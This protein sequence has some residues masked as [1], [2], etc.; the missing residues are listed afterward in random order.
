MPLV[1]PLSASSIVVT[2]ASSGIG[3]ATALLLAREGADLVL[4][5]RGEPGLDR[6]TAACVRLGSRAVAA[7]ADVADPEQVEDVYRTA[8]AVHGAVDAWA[9]VAGVAYYGRL[10]DAPPAAVL[11]VLD[12]NLMAHLYAV[13]SAAGHMLARG[14]GV[15]VLVG[16]ALSEL[17]MPYL[18]AYSLSKHALAALAATLRQELDPSVSV[19]TVMPSAVA[20][21]LF[22][23]AGNDTGR[24]PRPPGPPIPAWRAARRIV[25]LIAAPRRRSYTGWTGAVSALASRLAPGTAERFLARYGE[26][27]VL[28][29]DV[30]APPTDGN[31]YAAMGSAPCRTSNG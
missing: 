3:A 21:P 30:A 1:S 5:A 29:P 23:H 12:V 22:S 24:R 20:T 27:A 13:R 6:I 19:C 9:G 11:R 17:T 14:G 7:P 2:G 28:D 25:R 4:T 16:S 26:R 18:G 31:L 8:L 10:A 15:F